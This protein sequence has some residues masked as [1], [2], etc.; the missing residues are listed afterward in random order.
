[1]YSRVYVV[2][3]RDSEVGE[4]NHDLSVNNISSYPSRTPSLEVHY[5]DPYIGQAIEPTISSTIECAA[6]VKALK[7]CD[8]SKM[9]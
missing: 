1:M 2:W 8:E 9:D 5:L 6:L 3:N 4:I 7:F